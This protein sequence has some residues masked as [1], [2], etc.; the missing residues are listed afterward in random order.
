MRTPG[1]SDHNVLPWWS[2]KS[3]G[4]CQGASKLSSWLFWI[5]Q[6][7][8]NRSQRNHELWRFDVN[9]LALSSIP[10][11][12]KLS[13][14]RRTQKSF[15]PHYRPKS[16]LT[17]TSFHLSIAKTME[18]LNLTTPRTLLSTKYYCDIHD[19]LLIGEF[20]IWR[21]IFNHRY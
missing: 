21:N 7:P 17:V 8:S 19:I 3:R 9:F 1:V 11:F 4:T 20:V 13:V 2:L 10:H 5:F 18:K 14:F 6:R 12:A 16:C 15:L